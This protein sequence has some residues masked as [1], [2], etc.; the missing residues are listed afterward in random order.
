MAELMISDVFERRLRGFMLLRLDMADFLAPHLL[1]RFKRE[2]QELA[3]SMRALLQLRDEEHAAFRTQLEGERARVRRLEAALAQQGGAPPVRPVLAVPAPPLI[4]TGGSP[5]A[6]TSPGR[7]AS[8]TGGAT[9][10]H[11]AALGASPPS[12]PR[13]TAAVASSRRPSSSTGGLGSSA[14]AASRPS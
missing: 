4:T 10:L 11:H 9:T 3:A 2:E 5:P 14:P 8:S 12:I 7:L 13:S 1:E 6:P